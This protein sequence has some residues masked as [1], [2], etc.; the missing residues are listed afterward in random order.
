VPLL[1][2][3]SRLASAEAGSLSSLSEH[4]LHGSLGQKGF[5][6]SDLRFF[7]PGRHHDGHGGF[8]HGGF[9]HGGFHHGGFHHGGFH[10]GFHFY[11][12]F[13]VGLNFGYPFYSSHFFYP[14]YFPHVYVSFPFVGYYSYYPYP[15]IHAHGYHDCGF[16]DG[17]YVRF[18]YYRTSYYAGCSGFGSHAYH[19]HHHHVYDCPTHGYHYYHIRDC[20]LCYPSGGSYVYHDVEVPQVDP[21][22]DVGVPEQDSAAGSGTEPSPEARTLPGSSA[23]GAERAEDPMEREELFFASLKPAQLSF[24]LGLIHFREGHF[25]DAAE[26]FYNATIEDPESRLAK[27]FLA[28]ALFSVGE[29]EFAAEYLR[30][31]LVDWEAAAAYRWNLQA[32][33]GRPEDLESQRRLLLD[34]QRLYPAD[35]DVLLLLAFVE[36]ATGRENEAAQRFEEL[37]SSSQDPDAILLA[38][39]FLAEIE[40]RSSGRVQTVAFEGADEATGYFLETLDLGTVRD[41][42]LN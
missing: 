39:A 34:R 40:T 32:L 42:P 1:R 21:V 14:Y 31:G 35:S 27:A 33:Y 12:S 3:A 29:Y 4:G 8:D 41:L 19:Q 16:Y 5:G 15:Y 23:Q 22:V 24:A 10:H 30:E 38:G 17:Y 7:P 13:Y 6:G 18:G 28:H 37:R 36:F 9:H 2:T 25:D 11:P 26:A 20:A